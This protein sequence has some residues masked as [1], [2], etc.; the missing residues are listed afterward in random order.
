MGRRKL[1]GH[2][3]NGRGTPQIDRTFPA[4][5]G[6]IRLAC[7][8]HDPEAFADINAMLTALAKSVPPRYDVLE[9][10]RDR[11]IAPMHALSFYVL[12]RLNDVPTIDVLPL[13]QGEYDTWHTKLKASPEYK[14][15]IASTFKALL[16]LNAKAQVGDLAKLLRQRREQCEAAETPV[17]F[18]RS[19]SHV[20]AFV[21]DTL[22]DDHKLY[23]EVTKVPVLPV[24]DTP[25]RRGKAFE[26]LAALLAPLPEP[27]ASYAW[28]MACTGM[29]PK[30]YWGRWSRQPG[31]VD[32]RGTKRKARV[33]KVPLWAPGLPIV[34]VLSRSAFEG[35]WERRIGE[36]LGIYDLRR[37]FA[38]LMEDAGV[39]RSRRRIY[40]G[41]AAG[42]V[43]DLYETRELDAWREQD[44]AAML[45]LAGRWLPNNRPDMLVLHKTGA[46]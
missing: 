11:R 37:S 24:E 27:H 41:H 30:E 43:S 13:L 20:Q 46:A 2:R 18:N 4:P 36:G 29:G 5:I 9:A 44:G 17:G 42:D 35:M 40:M 3:S 32:I 22:G 26:E 33:R 12:N 45:A 16:A 21:R 10:I 19:K 25:E 8:T 1:R 34:P 7:G 28:S 39:T 6:Q 38:V 23:G 15:Q 14:A 31:L